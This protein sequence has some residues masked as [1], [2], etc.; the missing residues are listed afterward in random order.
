MTNNP[1]QTQLHMAREATFAHAFEFEGNLIFCN[2]TTCIGHHPAN[3][4]K[5]P[6]PCYINK[7]I[8]YRIETP[9]GIKG[10]AVVDHCE[11]PDDY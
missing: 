1:D 7:H 4:I 9:C 11:H 5:Y 10:T 3:F 2:N 8:V 6:M